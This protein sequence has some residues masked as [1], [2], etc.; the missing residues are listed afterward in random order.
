MQTEIKKIKAELLKD[1]SITVWELCPRGCCYE[2]F[3][4][5][6]DKGHIMECELFVLDNHKE[7]EDYKLI[8]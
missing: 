8:N 1:C 4:Y 6:F 5:Q 3:H 7:N 2:P